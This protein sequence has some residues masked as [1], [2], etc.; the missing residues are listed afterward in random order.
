MPK[1]LRPRATAAKYL[2]AIISDSFNAQEND[3]L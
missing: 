1:S 2:E 3:S